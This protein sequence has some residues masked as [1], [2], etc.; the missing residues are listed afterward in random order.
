[1]EYTN[2]QDMPQIIR[3]YFAYDHT[4]DY[5][6]RAAVY[7]RMTEQ[8]EE[9]P[10]TYRNYRVAMEKFTLEQLEAGRITEDLCVLYR[11]ISGRIC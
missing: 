2:L 4:L 5:K 9:E 8:K 6:K 1:M 3:M 11:H 7:R 10:Q